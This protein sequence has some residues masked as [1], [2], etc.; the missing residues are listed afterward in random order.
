M[1]FKILVQWCRNIFSF[2]DANVW[3]FTCL[4]MILMLSSI[5][6]T[7][8]FFVLLFFINSKW[9]IEKISFSTSLP[10]V[11]LPRVSSSCF[12]SFLF[13]KINISYFHLIF[14]G[15]QSQCDI[16]HLD[17]LKINSYLNLFMNKGYISNIYKPFICSHTP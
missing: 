12:L 1:V 15:L 10:W 4:H 7:F 11:I 2:P 13:W 3:K 16:Y 8:V 9:F 14:S 17:R 6:D 5:Y